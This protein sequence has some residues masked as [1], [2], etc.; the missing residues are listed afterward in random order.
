L[1][2]EI[3]RRFNTIYK[4]EIFPEPEP[5]MTKTAKLLGLDNRKMSKSYG[6]FIALSD[7]PEVIEKKVS[8]MITDPE[9]IKLADRGHPDICNVFNYFSTFTDAKNKAEVRDWCENAKIGCTE[10]KKRL[11]KVLIDYLAPIRERRSK[12]TDSK[13]EDILR[14]GNKKA[15]EAA[16]ETMDQVR[17]LINFIV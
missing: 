11:S 6:N 2:R 4:K 3:V 15:K 13:A 8:M 17:G 14:H 10:C 5:L 9:R 12:I 7:E 16:A 1:T